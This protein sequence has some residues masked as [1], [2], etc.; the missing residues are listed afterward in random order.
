MTENATIL[1][2]DISGFTEF[3]TRTEL[4]HS[5]HIINELLNLIISQNYSGFSLSE[6]EGDAVLFYKKGDILSKQLLVKQCLDIFSKFHEQLKY[7]ERDVV[8]RCGACQ[9]ASHL[10][11]KFI[12]HYGTIKEFRIADIVKASGIDMII[13]HRLLKNNINSNEYI[14][15][16]SS[17]LNGLSDKEETSGLKWRTHIEKY[18]AIGDIVVEFADLQEIK[19]GI[20]PIPE[21]KT[22]VRHEGG[23]T[24]EIEIEA[25]I[26]EVYQKLIDLDSIPK[27]MVGVTG[28]KRDIGVERIGTKHICMTPS[29]EMEVELDYAEFMEDTAIVVNKFNIRS[30][31]ISGVGTDYLK[32]IDDNTTLLTDTGIWEIPDE[33][34]Q[35]M[36]A[37]SRMSLEFFKA[38]CEGKEINKEVME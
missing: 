2:P 34:R 8:C 17:C 18:P 7:I 5:S 22:Y 14:L 31:G 30:L 37:S 20:P 3:V 11:L 33:F 12:I 6:I 16:S 27:W 23:D 15:I 1:I 19:K 36:L 10:S 32:K 21:R 24:M 13:A 29:L 35:E 38:L 28:I 25:T 26:E 9:S 4:D